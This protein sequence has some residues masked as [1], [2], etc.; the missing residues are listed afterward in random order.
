ML[1]ALGS[2][3]RLR[4]YRLLLRAGH[5]GLSVT[6]VQRATS[7]APSTL[8]HHIT[9]LV[10]SGLISQERV[11]RELICRAEYRE[12]RKLSA[13]LLQECCADEGCAPVRHEREEEIV[14]P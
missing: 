3:V 1:T 13:F 8:G 12:V 4:L 11:G 6:A 7:I 10:S 9:A 2:E 5:E 14:T